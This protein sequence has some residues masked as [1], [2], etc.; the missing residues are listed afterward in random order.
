MAPSV[1]TDVNRVINFVPTIHNDTYPTIDPLNANLSG[2]YVLITGASKGI[3]RAT[4]MSFARAGASGIA[5][6][7]RSD[8]SSLVPELH[9]AAE[10]A[11]RA[12]PK[13]LTLAADQ[14]NET[15]VQAAADKVRTEFGRLDILI[16]NAGYLEPW[17]PIVESDVNEWWKAF[18]VNVKGVYLMDRALI[19]LML[20]TENG[21]KTVITVS[22]RGAL[23]ARAGASAYQTSKNT[24][25]RL[26]NFLSAEYADQRLLVY[27]VHPGSVET[28]LARG[29][30]KYMYEHFYDTPELAGD[31]FVWLTKEKREW[32]NDRFISVAW[33][34]DEFLAKKE[35]VLKHDLLRYQLRT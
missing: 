2:K 16:N 3:G 24:V 1:A 27:T 15:Q 25:I 31:M 6:L 23:G 17:K 12:Q 26:N 30:P 4:A 29:M 7:A 19:P 22:S 18:E 14:T 35:M 5:I 34:A 28:D 8:L 32:L 21:D 10:K 13:I 20:E 33:D 9:T 11:G